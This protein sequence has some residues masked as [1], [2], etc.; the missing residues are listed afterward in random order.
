MLVVGLTGD[1]LVDEGVV[2]VFAA[3]HADDAL[4]PVAFATRRIC[5]R[6]LRPANR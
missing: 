4:P 2:F 6:R 3:G 5:S 1:R